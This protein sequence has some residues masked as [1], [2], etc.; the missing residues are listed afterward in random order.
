M[1]KPYILCAAIWY[2]EGEPLI[3][4]PHNI[5]KGF[6]VTGRRHNNIIEFVKEK[7]NR[8]TKQNTVQGFL[9]SDNRFVDRKEAAEVAWQA[10]QTR[11]R[12]NRL[13]SEDLY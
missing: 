12:E 9:T 5:K 2:Q 8:V 3:Y 1:K 6:V 7:L 10:G 13:F 4:S 11:V